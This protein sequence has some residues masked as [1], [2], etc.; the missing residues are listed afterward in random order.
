MNAPAPPAGR[1]VTWALGAGLLAGLASWLVGEL[2]RGTFKP[3]LQTLHVMGQSSGAA[4]R[5]LR[6]AD[7]TTSEPSVIVTNW[8][9]ATSRK[10]CRVPLVGQ[11]TDSSVTYVASSRPIDS[12]RLLP[13]NLE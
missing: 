12:T 1:L 3:P 2:V 7:L 8:S 9:A 4:P 6:R 13:P 11:V 5:A 10:I